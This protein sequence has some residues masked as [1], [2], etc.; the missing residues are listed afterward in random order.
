MCRKYCNTD[1]T[2][3]SL[4]GKFKLD[5]HPY[6]SPLGDEHPRH[7]YMDM[8]A[9]PP[10]PWGQHIKIMSENRAPALGYYNFPILGRQLLKIRL[11]SQTQGCKR[12]L[13][14]HG[15]SSIPICWSALPFLQILPRNT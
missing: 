1:H 6:W 3:I 8:G 5:P 12:T 2:E 9:P 15:K 10:R 14:Q 7:F 11:D 4:R 13:T